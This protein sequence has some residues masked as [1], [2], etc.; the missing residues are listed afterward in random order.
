VVEELIVRTRKELAEIGADHGPD[1]IRWALLAHADIAVEVPS[2][3]TI[4]RILI[5][6][7][8]VVAQPQKRP[9][10]SLH[11]F[12]YARPNECWQSDWTGWALADG[13]AVAIAGTLDDHSRLLVGIGGA[14]G[15]GTAELVWSV[16]ATAIGAY[17]VPSRSLTDN[18]TCYSV[19][20]RGGTTSAFETNLQAL[21]CQP[22]CS[23]PYHP[24]TCGKIERF[25]Q[26]LKKWLRAHE[27][28]HGHP[29]TLEQLNTTLGVFADY[30]N[31]Q[32][33]HRALGGRTPATAFA[34][35]I[36]ARPAQRPIPAPVTIHHSKVLSNGTTSAGPYLINVGSRWIGH[37]TTTIKDGDHIAI[38]SGTQ[39]IRVLDADPS[40][41][42]QPAKPGPRTYRRREPSPH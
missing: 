25:W 33:P 32:R 37:H 40:R 1:P 6:R 28:R 20:R 19:R 9:K 36:A 11:R 29:H 34:A 12:V 8:L 7:G 38:F 14:A 18:G 30:Y 31:Q 13:T 35:T 2:R 39:L 24:Q 41:T 16:M 5:R 27:A 22:I 17:G 3:A 21:G 42:Y 23:S 26:T 15:D 4:A 10:S